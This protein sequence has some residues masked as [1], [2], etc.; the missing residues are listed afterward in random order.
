MKRLIP[1]LILS[2]SAALAA[3]AQV[4]G[5]TAVQGAT[6]NGGNATA[7]VT[8]FFGPMAPKSPAAQHLGDEKAGR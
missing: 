6:A 4:Q 7:V 5:W 2:S 3:E 8:P 1:L